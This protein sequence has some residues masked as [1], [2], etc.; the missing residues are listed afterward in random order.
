[1]ME[2]KQL[3]R[4][5]SQ[6]Q[7]TVGDV[8]PE[9]KKN[10]LAKPMS[11]SD[12]VKQPKPQAH[13]EKNLL[14]SPQRY[15]HGSRESNKS[16]GFEHF[17]KEGLQ[18]RKLLENME[19]EYNK[20]K[21]NFDQLVLNK[22]R[23]IKEKNAMIN[24]YFTMD[25]LIKC[26]CEKDSHEEKSC[27]ENVS[28][29]ILERILDLNSSMSQVRNKFIAMRKKNELLKDVFELEMDNGTGENDRKSRRSLEESYHQLQ[30]EFLVSKEKLDKVRKLLEN[31]G[32]S[33]QEDFMKNRVQMLTGQVESRRNDMKR[34]NEEFIKA[35]NC[36]NEKYN[37][38]VSLCEQ[39][40]EIKKE[41]SETILN[42]RQFNLCLKENFRY[43]CRLR[44]VLEEREKIQYEYGA[45]MEDMTAMQNQFDIE[46]KS[47]EKWCMSL[48]ARLN[49]AQ[50]IRLE[51]D[52]VNGKMTQLHSEIFVR[53]GFIRSNEL[54]IEELTNSCKDLEEK[55][56]VLSNTE[57][58]LR[59]RGEEWQRRL[60]ETLFDICFA[61][62]WNSVEEED[63]GSA[64]WKSKLSSQSPVP[65]NS[66]YKEP[67]EC[68]DLESIE[69]ETS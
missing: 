7:L 22:K 69:Q 27:F 35:E 6:R 37:T 46:E 11:Y 56:L 36:Y 67:C 34:I 68:I 54:L 51:Q 45:V 29:N 43:D 57:M 62:S 12:S 30:I 24:N 33:K 17:R 53:H 64:E 44:E 61:I 39:C 21:E 66:E 42:R 23:S 50:Q 18:L 16:N 32:Q 48:V 15:D 9:V 13:S 8:W 65:R 52:H 40:K 25:D 59:N 20:V 14:I 49:E 19:E 60:T 3:Q 1:M 26:S 41:I 31:C 63:G 4:R 10:I 58:E 5:S 28:N 38:L 47:K 55:I 2:V